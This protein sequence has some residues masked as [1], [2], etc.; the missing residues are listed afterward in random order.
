MLS[1]WLRDLMPRRVK[2]ATCGAMCNF[3]DGDESLPQV[4]R[5][6]IARHWYGSCHGRNAEMMLVCEWFE[7]V[8]VLD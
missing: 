3:T 7:V 6:D 4:W 8:E 5:I 2:T 1:A